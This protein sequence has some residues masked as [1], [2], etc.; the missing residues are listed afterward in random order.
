MP[1]KELRGKEDGRV[2]PRCANVSRRVQQQM[3]RANGGPARG[4]A[5]GLKVA[6]T[7]A[8]LDGRESVLAKH[9]A[10]AVQ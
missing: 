3:R 4:S 7:I 1:Y 10:E 8:D 6:R 2:R 5:P 9:L